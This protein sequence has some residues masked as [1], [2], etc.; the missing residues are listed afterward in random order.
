MAVRAGDGLL[1]VA[2]FASLRQP[3]AAAR[4]EAAVT[5]VLRDG[6][7]TAD[8][9]TPG[10]RKVGTQEPQQDFKGAWAECSPQ[11]VG[12]F[13]AVGYFYGRVLHQMLDVPVGPPWGV[14]PWVS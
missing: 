10:A 5:R 12:G 4:I 9:H 8:I 6:L 7:R 13:S 1:G 3:E 2:T 14:A 11:T